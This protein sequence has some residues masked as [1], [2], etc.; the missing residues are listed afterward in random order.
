MQKVKYSS[1]GLDVELSVPAT[2]EEFDKNAGKVGACISEAINNVVYRGMLANFRYHFLHGIS[3]DDLNAD[4]E[5]KTFAP[6]TK[7]VKGV[8]EISGIERKVVPVLDAKTGKPR[9]KDGKPVETWDPADSEK[10][11][12]DRVLATKGVKAES[13]AETAKQVAAALV[14]DAS[15]TERA[16]R[17]PA[18]LAQRYKDLATLFITGKRNIDNMQAAFKKDLEGRQFSF[19]TEREVDGKKVPVAKNDPENIE[20]LGRMCKEWEAAQDVF[21][22]VK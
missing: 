3:Q 18:K 11:Y 22:K 1:L 8:D 5:N 6:G 7:P 21:S 16:E 13:F 9:V 17:G 2:I 20:A 10:K 15:E 12:F 4:K 19:I 14:F